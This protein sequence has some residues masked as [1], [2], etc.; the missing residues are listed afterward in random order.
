M[1]AFKKATKSQAKLR[2]AIFGP[3]G[4]GKTYTSLRIATG[5][6]GS[7]AV[8]DSERG[9]AS[10]YA[11][12]FSFDVAELHDKSIS[13]YV[14]TLKEAAGHYDVVIIDSLSHAWSELLTEIDRLANAKY[15][16][17]TWSAW[18]EGTP[19]QRLLVD[20]ILDFPG[21]VIA[22]M[23]A[24]T[25]WQTETGNGGKSRPVR[26][27]MSPE[28]GKGIEYE[29]DVLFELSTDHIVNVIKDRSGKFQDRLIQFPGEEFGK[30]LATWLSDGD[31]PK[32]ESE[33]VKKARQ[34]ITGA[35]KPEQL[36][37]VK[38]LL[39]ERL[40]TKHITPDDHGVLSGMIQARLDGMTA[41]QP[42][43]VAELNAQIKEGANEQPAAVAAEA[44]F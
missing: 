21:H 1:G 35:T 11:D 9:S 44:M 34:A 22:T 42:A 15:R 14:N 20:A 36:E 18:S 25:E 32:P 26:V 41:A 5:M 7:I 39:A 28:Q 10:K 38:G 29:F 16:G 27:G 37:K 23:R 40:K 8:I 24:K 33:L 3:S 31:Q 6:G 19:K 2:A 30:E 43:A 13:S 4:A 12:R 17:N